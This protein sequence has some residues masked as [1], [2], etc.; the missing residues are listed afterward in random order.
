MRKNLIDQNIKVYF[1]FSILL[2]V[3]ISYENLYLST[4]I[5]TVLIFLINLYK[6]KNKKL[7]TDKTYVVFKL[8]VYGFSLFVLGLTILKVRDIKYIVYS[9]N[10]IIPLILMVQIVD[11]FKNK[12]E[13][14]L[15]TIVYCSNLLILGVWF[16]LIL[17]FFKI[18]FLQ[19][20]PTIS[21]YTL[22]QN[23]SVFSEYRISGLLSHKSRF[24]IYCILAMAVFL[25]LKK[26]NRIANMLVIAS[27]FYASFL[28]DSMTTFIGL[29]VLFFVYL[30]DNFIKNNKIL[31]QKIFYI[32]I[33]FM[34]SLFCI[35]SF[36]KNYNKV[37]EGRNV[38][39]LG[40][41]TEIWNYSINYIKDN[42]SGTIKIPDDLRL[43]G[44]SYYDNAHNSI[45]NEYI[46]TGIIGG[47]LFL[48]I[49]IYSIFLIEDNFMKLA[50]LIV[51]FCCQFDKVLY[52]ETT[53]IYWGIA[54][55][56]IVSNKNFN[57]ELKD[58]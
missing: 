51:L 58:D 41:R 2:I 42:K 13:K 7:Y 32:S 48:I 36:A 35:F 5:G 37:Y 12:P 44:I 55:L 53:F 33:I 46:E 24:G 40:S 18:A 9:I 6:I 50:Y 4:I 54:A 26:R 56:F 22:M 47:T 21:K 39:T 27:I 14:R 1:F 52:N 8:L 30:Y 49:C 43:N 38:Q 16:A 57:K 45:L 19:I 20:G 34:L 29:L 28:S 31:L 10:K 17:Y 25:N 23:Y 3:T 15:K 11:Y